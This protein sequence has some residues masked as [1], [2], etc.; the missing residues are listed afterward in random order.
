MWQGMSI[1]AGVLLLGSAGVNYMVMQQVQTEKD[2]KQTAENN[3]RDSKDHRAKALAAKEDNTKALTEAT[4]QAQQADRDL[5]DQKAKTADMVKKLETDT[6]KLDQ[7]KKEKDE[8]DKKLLDLGGIDQ[9]VSTLQ[10][11]TAKKA[12]NEAAIQQ[13]QA[14]QALA[15]QR[16]QQTEGS[17][18][19]FKKTDLMQKTGILPDGLTATISQVDPFSGLVLINRG[20]SSRVVKNARLDVKRGGS[21]IATLVVTNIQPTTAVCD[22]VPG[23]LTVPDGVQPG[24]VVSVNDASSEKNLPKVQ[25]GG[26]A[27]AGAAPAGGTAPATPAPAADPF[28][29][30]GGAP[31]PAAPSSPDPFAPSAPAAPAAPAGGAAPA[32]PDA[33]APGAVEAPKPN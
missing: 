24:D 2:L 16:K 11:L 27:P 32:T 9:L 20:N 10:Q 28:A 23:S 13:K 15:L 22:V 7:T 19:S 33:P 5:Q 25:E 21:K 29:A 12:E 8:L 14:A 30:P 26:A 18:V 1:F 31:A 4:A 17:I 3:A 6:A